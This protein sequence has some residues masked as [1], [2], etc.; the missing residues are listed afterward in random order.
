MDLKIIFKSKICLLF[1]L[2]NILN[3]VLG[4]PVPDTNTK[5]ADITEKSKMGCEKKFCT[6]FRGI[7]TNGGAC[8]SGD[9]CAGSCHCT[10]NYKGR[11]CQI[12]T[13][14]DYNGNGNGND[15][16]NDDGNGYEKQNSPPI[17]KP[18]V[19]VIMKLF[20][21]LRFKG[22]GD[23]SISRAA[24]EGKPSNLSPTKAPPVKVLHLR[25]QTAKTTNLGPGSG[26]KIGER[27]VAQRAIT[28][29][30]E[31][32]TASV[33]SKVDRNGNAKISGKTN[34]YSTVMTSTTENP[35]TAASQKKA[36]QSKTM[37]TISSERVKLDNDTASSPSVN[38]SSIE[39]TTSDHTKIQTSETLDQNSTSMT[40]IETRSST[41]KPAMGIGHIRFAMTEHLLQ[42]KP[43]IGNKIT[44]PNV[45]RMIRKPQSADSKTGQAKPEISIE[46]TELNKT[47]KNM[48]T[49]NT[50]K[51]SNQSETGKSETK[52]ETAKTV[53]TKIIIGSSK[54]KLKSGGPS[55]AIEI[56]I[57]KNKDVSSSRIADSVASSIPLSNGEVFIRDV[58]ITTKTRN[59][60]QQPKTDISRA[61]AKLWQGHKTLTTPVESSLPIISSRNVKSTLE[62]ANRWVASG[63]EPHIYSDKF[64]R[65]NLALVLGK[66]FLQE[67]EV[68]RVK[69]A[70]ND[71]G[72][73]QKRNNITSESEISGLTER[74]FNLPETRSSLVT[75]NLISSPIV[76]TNRTLMSFEHSGVN[77]IS[78]RDPSTYSN[79]TSALIED[80]PA[81]VGI[82]EET[83]PFASLITTT[84]SSSK[85]G[86]KLPAENIY[87]AAALY[88]KFIPPDTA[89]KEENGRLKDV[90]PNKVVSANTPTNP[91]HESVQHVL[92]SAIHS[93]TMSS[94]IQTMPPANSGTDI[95]HR[96]SDGDETLENTDKIVAADRNDTGASVGDTTT[97][98]L[99][100]LKT[101]LVYVQTIL[102]STKSELDSRTS[103]RKTG[104]E[105]PATTTRKEHQNITES[106]S[107]TTDSPKEITTTSGHI[108]RPVTKEENIGFTTAINKVLQATT[109]NATEENVHI[110]KTSETTPFDK[111]DSSDSTD[112]LESDGETVIKIPIFTKNS[113]NAVL[114]TVGPSV[115][116]ASKSR[117]K[118]T[119][120]TVGISK[121]DSTA[122]RRRV[123]TSSIA[124]IL[125]KIYGIG[126]LITR[127]TTKTTTTATPNIS[128]IKQ[129]HGSLSVTNKG[130]LPTSESSK[131]SNRFKNTNSKITAL[132]MNQSGRLG[133]ESDQPNENKAKGYFKSE[134][135]F[136]QNKT[137]RN[138]MGAFYGN[139]DMVG[140]FIVDSTSTIK[141][142]TIP[143]TR[144]LREG[145]R[146]PTSI[147]SGVKDF[148][149][150][151][152]LT[153]V[154][155]KTNGDS[156]NLSSLQTVTTDSPGI[157]KVNIS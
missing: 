116:E 134:K 69:S 79:S 136:Q 121:K 127:P 110:L 12:K 23:T 152:N 124:R 47:G 46:S 118:S 16:G 85:A 56:P 135:Y 10:S 62:D 103:T 41:V 157:E 141:P 1:V 50:T 99:E 22:N 51:V 9:G 3:G 37:T 101:L 64:P 77:K 84:E 42:P 31:S 15:N 34:D 120:S 98:T 88:K 73:S 156:V 52:T 26:N 114:P 40:E 82:V 2:F 43:R 39:S 70:S 28:N 122:S 144:D 149:K 106:K 75:Q 53:I 151:Q 125:R 89:A 33:P 139:E 97:A 55:S 131:Q 36:D 7:C 63:F 24:N 108:H 123:S 143:P 91:K 113:D 4:I 147:N 67:E 80:E 94:D 117:P 81:N 87:L 18:A 65:E 93:S 142:Y 111:T 48:T 32:S 148:N 102:S 104:S 138:E 112:V 59:V 140:N 137:V 132:A 27:T 107:V 100:K 14:E 145:V 25:G 129:R 54:T 150:P 11:Y 8:V 45:M 30:A 109:N 6:L 155:Q 130:H 76:K 68:E 96:I 20:K 61:A 115:T 119:V 5:A 126:N 44:E 35:T 153:K 95:T 72:L 90:V 38:I 92:K 21:G 105:Q 128:D 154:N 74:R 17:K 58:P 29:V 78:S 13:V 83:V 60:N 19:G 66:D 86:P 146:S 49:G 71:I 133:S 57:L